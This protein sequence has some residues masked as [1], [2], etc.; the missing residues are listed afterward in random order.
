MPLRMNNVCTIQTK[1][2]TSTSTSKEPIYT[3]A[4]TY[5]NV[6]CRISTVGFKDSPQ[7]SRPVGLLNTYDRKIHKIFLGPRIDINPTLHRIKI[8]SGPFAGTYN[9]L[10]CDAPQNRRGIDHYELTVE[11]QA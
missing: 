6:K 4:D 3:W 1:T 8:A 9:I 11:V 7:Q 2:Q 5:A 10:I